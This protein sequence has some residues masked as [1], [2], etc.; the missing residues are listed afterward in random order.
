MSGI[1]RQPLGLLSFFGVKNTGRNPSAL[2]EIIAPTL[3]LARWYLSTNSQSTAINANVAVVGFSSFLT[4][5]E[6]ETW[7]VLACTVNSQNALGAGQTLRIG[8][9]FARVSPLGN[10]IHPLTLYGDTA[11]TGAVAASWSSPE[12]IVFVPPGSSIGIYTAAIA[13]GPV[14]S[15]LNLNYV[16]MGV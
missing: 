8:G 16:A 1:N 5:P 7:A 4:V 2:A 6:T 9:A 3:D 14:P 15:T 13:A 11:T 10:V 12:A